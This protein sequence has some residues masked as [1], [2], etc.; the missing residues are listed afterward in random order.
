MP[1]ASLH[2]ASLQGAS[3]PRA[4]ELESIISLSELINKAKNP[5]RLG[6]HMRSAFIYLL[7]KHTLTHGGCRHRQGHRISLMLQSNLC[8]NLMGTSI[9]IYILI[10]EPYEKVRERLDKIKRLILI[11]HYLPPS[12]TRHTPSSQLTTG[13]HLRATYYFKLIALE[14]R[15]SWVSFRNLSSF[16]RI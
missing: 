11:Y 6:S 10:I 8:Y 1:E 4:Y 13:I 7:S 3:A 15:T 16:T 9:Y 14:F 12:T 2:K 5:L